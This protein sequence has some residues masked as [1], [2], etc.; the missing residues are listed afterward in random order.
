[1][2]GPVGR[3][4][5]QGAWYRRA[6]L[7]LLVLFAAL[8]LFTTLLLVVPDI[9]P[10]VVNDRLDLAILTAALL[11]SASVS[12]L[13]WSRG[14]V[15][16][17]AAALLRGSA[18]AVLALL[19]GVNLTIAVVGA[20]AAF[21]ASLDDPGQ[22]PLIAGHR[23]PRGQRDAPR[24]RGHGGAQPPNAGVASMAGACRPCS[25]G[26]GADRHRLPL[27]GHPDDAR[28]AGGARRDRHRPDRAAAAR[29]GAGVGRG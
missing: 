19:N 9:A 4:A 14:R 18:F 23:G 11:V 22:L 25:D 20:D 7:A 17:D 15:A 16:N 26:R 21:G 8:T 12:A 28:A 3:A 6:D 5:R 24:G 13:A 2:T 27:A 10:A 29:I 1:M